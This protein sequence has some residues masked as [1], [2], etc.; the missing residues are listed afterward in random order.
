MIDN[1]RYHTGGDAPHD[2]QPHFTHRTLPLVCPHCQRP[3]DLSL[4]L[5]G[6]R[7]IAAILLQSQ[8]IGAELDCSVCGLRFVFHRSEHLPA[9]PQSRMRAPASLAPA[10][11]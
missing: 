11:L 1:L 7:L 6:N 4:G 2:P 10:H 8:R 9:N 3:I 5:C